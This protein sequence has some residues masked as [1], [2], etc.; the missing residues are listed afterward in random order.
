MNKLLT[1]A[2]ICV[3]CG[4]CLPTCP[5]YLKTENENESPR[6]RIAL[7]QAW[8]GGY[9]HDANAVRKHIDNCLLCRECERVCPAVMPYSQLIDN[10]RSQFF[11]DKKSSLAASLLKEVAQHKSAQRFTQ[12]SLKLY[13][14][15]PL[16]KIARTLKL[17]NL[18][19]LAKVERLLSHYHE[20]TE[21]VDYYPTT[22]ECKGTVG[23]FIGCM[24]TLLDFATITAAIKVL[25][26]VGFNVAIPSQQTCCGALALHNGD[27]ASVEK[28]AVINSDEFGNHDLT[29]IVTIAS[30][31]GGQLQAYTQTEFA[32]KV[33]DISQFLMQADV[34]LHEK[35][36]PLAASVCLHTPCSLK[37]VM[38]TEQGALQLLQQIPE[39][40]ITKLPKAI[41]CCGSAGS[42]MIEHAAMAEAILA[43][44]LDAAVTTE[45][46]YLV[47]S[48]I[49]C[50]LHI[51]A[52]LQERGITMEVLHPVVLIAQQ[53][54]A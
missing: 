34:N 21:L 27:S 8:A 9:L 14:T 18:V 28:S 42:Y 40:K 3:K 41:I 44:L 5:T 2:D 13:Q 37:N 31:C 15:T 54:K 20:P 52:G 48:N 30:G 16:Q 46:N 47:S 11:A 43:D 35:L 17:P 39:L 23:L 32:D 26:A 36:Q 25:T 10:F 50:V 24:G 29:A 53:L 33:M 38:R 4:L 51:A 19:G 45:A 49:G 12:L 6:G 1:D 7:I 22:T